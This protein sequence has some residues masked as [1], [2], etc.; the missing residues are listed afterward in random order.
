MK[1]LSGRRILIFIILTLI[2]TGSFLLLPTIFYLSD[3][4]SKTHK[5]DANILLVEGWLPYHSLEM[6]AREFEKNGYDYL[7]TT[8]IESEFEYTM[9]SMDGY[10]IF[11]PAAKIPRDDVA[12]THLIEIDAY[13]ELGGENSAQFN[14]YVND[15]LNAD[16]RAV[17]KKR[18]YSMIWEGKLSDIDSI[19]VQFINDGVGDYGDRN[20]FVKQIIIDKDI[21]IP[22]QNL[23]EYDIFEL[24]GKNRIKNNFKSYAQ[25]AREIF[26]SLGIDSS[27]VISVPGESV[28][29]NRTFTSALAVRNW[30]KTSDIEVKG[31]N[32]ISVDSHSRRT[33]MTYNKVLHKSFNVGVI[34]LP[35][36]NFHSRTDKGFNILKETLALVYYWVI[37]IPF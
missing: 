27:N 24:D 31:I 36:D 29:I 32:I 20:L 8:G 22:Y 7:I 19:M 6:A 15:S 37:L 30:L 14:F 12:A 25:R 23:S 13:S 9:L 10:L 4:L 18:K 34:S 28:K 5:V 3:H 21:S 2:L 33:W 11:Y 17:R 1:L 16:F 26:I 35:K